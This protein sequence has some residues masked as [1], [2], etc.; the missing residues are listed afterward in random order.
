MKKPANEIKVIPAWI[1]TDV[2]KGIIYVNVNDPDGDIYRIGDLGKGK[3]PF[4]MIWRMENGF[5]EEG[6]LLRRPLRFDPVSLRDCFPQEEGMGLLE[7]IL[8][9]GISC[10]TADRYFLVAWLIAIF[11]ADFAFNRPLLKF[12]GSTGSGKT[13][14]AGIMSL[15]VT[16]KGLLNVHPPLGMYSAS[17]RTPLIGV[18]SVGDMDSHV[19]KSLRAV[20]EKTLAVMAGMQSEVEITPKSLVIVTDVEPFTRP[21][22]LRR[23]FNVELSQRF[24]HP[25]FDEDTIVKHLLDTRNEI[26]TSILKVIA[27][28]ILPNLAEWSPMP[29]IDL[30]M[31]ILD[32]I[33]KYLSSPL[34][35]AQIKEAWKEKQSNY[36][37]GAI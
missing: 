1:R 12:S 19:T 23:S 3:V 24:K 17:Q 11:L 18:D 35:V 2:H 9:D 31:V 7:D 8:L 4:P 27:A 34:E 21:E 30:M 32:N 22:L 13:T 14:A 33:W 20:T 16:G 29:F 36:Q 10:S 37:K 6:I 5:N 15:L 25:E 28:D 26:L